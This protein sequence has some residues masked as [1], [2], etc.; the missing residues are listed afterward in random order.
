MTEFFVT[1]VVDGD[2]FKVS[3]NWEWNGRSGDTVRPAGY[4]TPE[5]GAPGYEEAKEKLTELILNKTVDI[6][7]Y[8]TIDRDRLVAD[9]YYNGK[10][11]ADYFPE[12]RV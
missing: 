3:S 6:K 12:Y 4:N 1:E 5:Q 11:L 2:T 9:V 10:N 8:Q 7:N